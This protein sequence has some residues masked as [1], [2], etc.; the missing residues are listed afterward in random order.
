[1]VIG[2]RTGKPRLLVMTDIGGDPDD[3]QSMIRLMCYSNEFDLEGLIATGTNSS[4]DDWV[5]PELIREI[6]GAYGK[7]REN[8]LLHKSGY[9]AE[10]ELLDKIKTGQPSLDCIGEGYDTEGSDWIISCADREDARPLYIAIWGGATDLAQAVWK[11]KNSRKAEAFDA[12]LAKLFVY[13]INKQDSGIDWLLENVPKL[14]MVLSV[15]VTNKLAAA[16]RGMYLGGEETLTS[17]GWIRE[18]IT[19]GHGPL[20]DLYPMRAGTMPN[21]HRCMKEGDT[22]SWFYFLSGIQGLGNPSK[23][24]Q[25]SW[26]GRFKKA[27]EYLWL[28]AEDMVNGIRDSRATVWRWRPEYQNDWAARMDWCVKPFAEANHPPVAMVGGALERQVA[29]GATVTLDA[30]ESW[31]PD[32]NE[33][34]YEWMYYKE[35][36][37]WEGEL[38][39]SQNREKSLEFIAPVTPVTTELHII[40]KVRD[41]GSPTLTGYQRVVVRVDPFLKTDEEKEAETEAGRAMKNG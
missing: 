30:S 36:G 31:D 41:S 33:L 16:Y 14:L 22:P 6:V 10:E 21:P 39:F 38:K 7:V 20:G 13:S 18:H 27:S 26:G 11:V 8:L 28:D 15:N 29:P 2:D 23:P 3:Q 40:L 32:G 9:P 25:G 17:T 34:S 1:M 35:A 12:F 5:H 24:G 37:T 4:H 19:E